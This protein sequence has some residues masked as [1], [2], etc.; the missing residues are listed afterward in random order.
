M[1][2]F[3]GISRIFKVVAGSTPALGTILGRICEVFKQSCE[4]IPTLFEPGRVERH[5]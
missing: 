2:K 1:S 5:Y 4:I 3:I